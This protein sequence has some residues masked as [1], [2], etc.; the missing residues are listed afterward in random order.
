MSNNGLTAQEAV[1]ISNMMICL[2]RLYISSTKLGDHGAKLLSEGIT[3][4]KTLRVLNISKNNIGPSGT[5]T[6]A[7]AL[8]NNTSL[9]ELWMEDNE[10]GQDGTVPQQLLK[11]LLKTLLLSD[12]TM[13]EES[14]MIIMKSLHCNNTITDLRLYASYGLSYHYNVQGEIRERINVMRKR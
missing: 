10:Y 8:T 12:S 4:T 3:N 2:E 11:P 7:D 9:E 14:A 5:T 6:I 1:A 13:D